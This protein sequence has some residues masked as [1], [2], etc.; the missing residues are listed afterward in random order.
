MDFAVAA[1][2]VFPAV[3]PPIENGLV[4]VNDGRIAAVERRREQ[5]ADRDFGD[6]AI[7]P[8][9][10]NAHTHLDLT[11]MRGLA[12]PTPDFVAWLREVIAHRRQR[13]A[14]EIGGDIR[15]GID[16]SLRGHDV[17]RRHFRRWI[18]LAGTC[19]SAN[20]GCCVSRN[21]W[22]DQG[23]RRA[24]LANRPAMARRLRADARRPAR[25]EPAR[26]L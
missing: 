10:V 12:P 1:R 5:K 11:G 25:I 23:T 6:A 26:A 4:V 16:E 14:A 2:W 24:I 8:G 15:D 18:E 19:R 3:G 17:D 13:G 21:A 9:L 22:A 7:L 20:A